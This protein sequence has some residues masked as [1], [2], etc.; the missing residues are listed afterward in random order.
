MNMIK[1]ET[2]GSDQPSDPFNLIV[3]FIGVHALVR[4]CYGLRLQLAPIR[5]AQFFLRRNVAPD[6]KRQGTPRA[7]GSK[8]L[9]RFDIPGCTPEPLE[10]GD[11]ARVVLPLEYRDIQVPHLVTRRV[12]WLHP[13]EERGGPSGLTL[14]RVRMSDSWVK[15]WAPDSGRTGGC[16]RASRGD[17]KTAGTRGPRMEKSKPDLLHLVEEPGAGRILGGGT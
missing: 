2:S 14:A 4:E 11:V 9:M 7:K 13:A 15:Y 16:R 5:Q 8:H 10:G 17:T 3:I 6:G 12:K 1:Q